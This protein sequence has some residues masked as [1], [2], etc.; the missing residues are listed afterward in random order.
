MVN[1]QSAETMPGCLFTTLAPA[2][3]TDVRLPNG[4][5]ERGIIGGPGVFSMLGARIAAGHTN[6]KTIGASFTVGIDLMADQ[7]GDL[8]TQLLALGRDWGTPLI[9]KVVNDMFASREV[10]DYQYDFLTRKVTLPAEVPAST[11]PTDLAGTPMLYA[12]SIHTCDE[13]RVAARRREA[14]MAVRGLEVTF[15]S[16]EHEFRPTA[17]API[18]VWEPN[19]A[20]CNRSQLQAHKDACKSV[21]VFSPCWTDL[22]AMINGGSGSVPNR[23][24]IEAL[25]FVFLKS[26]IGKKTADGRHQGAIVVR[27]GQYGCF[28]GKQMLGDKDGFESMWLPA[29]YSDGSEE[30]VD[31]TG[32]GSAFLGAMA[33][34]MATGKDVFRAAETASVVASFVVEQVGAPGH[35]PLPKGAEMINGKELEEKAEVYNKKFFAWKG[36]FIG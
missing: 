28:V 26:G 7:Q 3:L 4:Q 10:V 31:P 1:T 33:W 35:A 20:F 6:S 5:E 32:A 19:P 9:T 15:A 13:P 8:S 36:P 2:M 22:A 23:V 16:P 25:A 24:E 17:P 11:N 27:M 30:V 18:M 12:H 21:D 29:F 34:L 14:I